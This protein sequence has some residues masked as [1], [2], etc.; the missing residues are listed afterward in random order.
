MS[1]VLN[2]VREAMGIGVTNSNGNKS[3]ET[4]KDSKETK[5][6]KKK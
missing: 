5:D 4:A 1:K 2:Q 6:S 3:D